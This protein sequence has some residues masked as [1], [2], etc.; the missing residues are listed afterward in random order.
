MMKMLLYL[1][2]PLLRY[3]VCAMKYTIRQEFAC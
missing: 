3:P 1:D 2:V